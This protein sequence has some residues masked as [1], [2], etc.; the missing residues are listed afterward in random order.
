VNYVVRTLYYS[1][2]IAYARSE[3]TPKS[4]KFS[5][6]FCTRLAR[7]Q[8]LPM[9]F[10]I[11]DHLC[12][13]INEHHMRTKPY[14]PYR[15]FSPSGISESNR[16]RRCCSETNHACLYAPD[17]GFSFL[18]VGGS[19]D[20][21]HLSVSERI[22]AFAVVA[23]VEGREIKAPSVVAI[24]TSALSSTISRGMRTP[25]HVVSARPYFGGVC[26]AVV[27]FH[28]QGRAPV[29]ALHQTMS[30]MRGRMRRAL[31]RL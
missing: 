28:V 31:A 6:Y 2:S 22:L 24:S 25:K 19:I 29:A 21:V 16:S 14:A 10:D 13:K 27:P 30:Q 26:G 7:A 23:G 12:K 15:F 18:A 9:A 4:F 1:P 11:L 5:K 8:R 3:F 17:L 20:G